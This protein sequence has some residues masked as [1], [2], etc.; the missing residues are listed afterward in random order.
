[1]TQEE[2][3]NSLNIESM[4]EMFSFCINLRSVNF[5]NIKTPKLKSIKNIFKHNE[6]LTDI[7]FG[8]LD[9]SKVITT[10]G[11]FYSCYSIKKLIYR[12]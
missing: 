6:A 3:S 4:E 8:N 7:N 5:G 11:M 12:N 10:H 9:T 1:L 2:Q